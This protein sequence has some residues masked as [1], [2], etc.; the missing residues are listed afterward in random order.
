MRVRLVAMAFLAVGALAGGCSDGN[1]V[2]SLEERLAG[3]GRPQ[4]EV[5]R[6]MVECLQAAD[7]P[8]HEQSLDGIVDGLDG[9]VAVAFPDDQV[10]YLSDGLGVYM[11]SYGLEGEEP[12]AEWAAAEAAAAKYADEYGEIG[13]G[14]G[15]PFLIIGADDYTDPWV[16]C[17]DETGYT[18]PSST[19]NLGEELKDKQ[20]TLNATLD[21]LNCARANG[22]P[23]LKDPDPPKADGYETQPMALLPADISEAELRK[24]LVACPNFN[25]EDHLGA[26]QTEVD[27]SEADFEALLKKYPG[28]I[29][30]VIGFDV[31]GFNGDTHDGAMDGLSAADQNRLYTLLDIIGAAAWEYNAER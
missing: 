17:L 3:D 24:L 9:Q 12:T 5:A 21:W 1:D 4:A 31:P 13:P 11:G 20:R 16:K 15:K 8:A 29:D 27:G 25:K 22:Y 2:A 28:M 7:V 26:D 10:L 14:P 30:P 23:K 18:D 19:S 6:A